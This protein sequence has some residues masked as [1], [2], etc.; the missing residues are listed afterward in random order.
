MVIW[1]ESAPPGRNRADRGEISRN[2]GPAWAAGLASALG[3]V[4]GKEVVAGNG[5][6][7]MGDAEN[8]SAG[9]ASGRPGLAVI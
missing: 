1:A 3:V 7:G 5:F 4:A 6:E 2:S 9:L 8:R